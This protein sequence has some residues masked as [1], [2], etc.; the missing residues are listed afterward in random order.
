[1]ASEQPGASLPGGLSPQAA[2]ALLP[3]FAQ[4]AEQASR[5][6]PPLPVYPLVPGDERAAEALRRASSFVEHTVEIVGEV[7]FPGL[8]PIVKGERLSSVLRRAGGYTDKAYLRGAVFTRESVRQALR[9]RLQ[10]LLQK[11]E[12]DLISAS[13]TAATVALTAETSAAQLQALQ[14]R[15]QLL[16]RLRTLRPEGRVV[17]QLRP[18]EAFAGSEHDLELE[19]GDRLHIPQVLK[20]VNILGQVYNPASLLHEPG[21]DI[22]FYLEKVGGVKRE[23]N[24]KEIHV[25]QI[26]GTV[27]S[28]SQDRFVSL[29]ADGRIT[30]LGDFFSVHPQPGDTIIV[31]RRFRTFAS[32]RNARDIVQILFQSITTAAVI[33]ALL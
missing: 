14:A 4:Q 17:I 24:E 33:L 2:Q 5:E 10:Q 31:P 1:M 28:N 3:F 25:V 9:E 6:A 12:E 23:A 32:L 27:I 7:R 29:E 30:Y 21:R 15:R 13:A 8:Y 19:P 22:G 11:E 20:Y 16:E 26:D 18:M